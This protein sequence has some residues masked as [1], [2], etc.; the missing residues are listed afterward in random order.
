MKPALYTASLTSASGRTCSIA[1]VVTHWKTEGS[2]IFERVAPDGKALEACENGIWRITSDDEGPSVLSIEW[3]DN[4]EVD[5]PICDLLMLDL[6]QQ[7][8]VDTIER[9]G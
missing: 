3:P 8:G 5:L 1:I 9:Q 4:G 7:M 6:S 2:A